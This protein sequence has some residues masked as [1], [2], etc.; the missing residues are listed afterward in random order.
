MRS[1]ADS[2]Y[3]SEPS[4]TVHMRRLRIKIEDDP[5]APRV[6]ETVWGYGYR[7]MPYV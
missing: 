3:R 2:S 7:L 1:G 5:S 4:V 6:I